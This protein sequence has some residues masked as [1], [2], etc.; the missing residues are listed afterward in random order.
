MSEAQPISTFT[1]AHI[2]VFGTVQGVGYRVSTWQKANQ[3][4]VMGWVRNLKDGRVEAVFEGPK[5]K[6][7]EMVNW[8]KVGPSSAIV[9]GIDVTY[10]SVLGLQ[11]FQIVH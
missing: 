11:D 2:F 10:E 8:C 6:V 4:N 1:C 9:Q 3:L 5:P 7:D